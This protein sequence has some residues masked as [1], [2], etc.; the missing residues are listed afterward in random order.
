M[1]IIPLVRAKYVHAFDGV[2]DRIGAPR[3]R[4]LERV[5][6]SER[7]LEDPEAIIPAKQAW[8]FIGV[9]A[10]SE[11]I[12]DLGLV[13]GDM[14][15]QD[16]GAF[17]DQLLRVPNLY[18]ALKAFCR[19]ALH[20][21]SRADFY[22][23]QSDRGTWFCRG[24]IDGDDAEKKHVELLV[25]TM[26]IATVR[27]AAGPV[28][29]PPIVF[30]Q[31]NDTRRVQQHHL[32]AHSTIRFGNRV[33]AFEIPSHIL[34]KELPIALAPNDDQN[35][36]RLN[37]EFPV[38]I[39]QVV[40]SMLVDGAPK[41]AAVANAVGASVRTLQ[42]RLSEVD[43]TFSDIVEGA[44]MAS[45]NH[46]VGQSDRTFTEIAHELGYS[47]Q[48]HFTRAFRRWTGVAPA[49][50]RRLNAQAKSDTD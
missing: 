26:M 27:L 23:S 32:F 45:A 8:A 21:Y 40:S 25:L 16:Y 22:V 17:S 31:T 18:Q 9:A 12:D 30:L 5:G 41:I 29:H 50:F 2:L 49:A 28:W 10:Q 33:T 20:E 15:I 48:A 42:R 35:Y 6:L 24:P 47:D 14:S 3:R 19:L 46:M 34:T 36:D 1:Q 13:A 7:V 4:L 39:R 38:S 37:H 44:K 11:G 43:T